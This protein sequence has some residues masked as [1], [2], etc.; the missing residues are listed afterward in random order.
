MKLRHTAALVWLGWYLMIPP[1][2]PRPYDSIHWRSRV[3]IADWTVVGTFDSGV[4]CKEA[5]EKTVR[6]ARQKEQS[7]SPSVRIPDHLKFV[8]IKNNAACI[9]TGDPRLAK[10]PLHSSK[11]A[12]PR[13][14]ISPKGAD[15]DLRTLDRP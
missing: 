12:S 13:A 14:R 1:D 6:K 7:D 5:L 2:I 15:T 11:D 3:P 4:T 8:A 9:P 10:G